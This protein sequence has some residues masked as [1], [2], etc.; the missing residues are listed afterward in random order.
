MPPAKNRVAQDDSGSSTISKQPAVTSQA[1]NVRNKRQN[2][3]TH[4][5]GRAGKE[6]VV[7]E[8]TTAQSAQS[9]QS[10]NTGVRSCSTDI[11][12]SQS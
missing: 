9:A 12:S 5:N 11:S 8:D 6:T 7:A 2:T 4:Q 3:T 1:N 10:S